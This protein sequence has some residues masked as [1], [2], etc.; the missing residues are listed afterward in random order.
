MAY[1]HIKRRIFC[2]IF[3][4][5]YITTTVILRSDF[6]YSR[7]SIL[8]TFHNCLLESRYIAKYIYEYKVTDELL[9]TLSERI[10]P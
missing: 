3:L 10:V 7:I 4:I 6:A 5:Y 1:V 9:L 8:C 2:W